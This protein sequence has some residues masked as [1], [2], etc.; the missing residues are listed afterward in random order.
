MLLNH[1]TESTL[2]EGASMLSSDPTGHRRE[3]LDLMNRLQDVGV[4]DMGDLNIPLIAVIGSQSSGK[5]S[6]IEAISGITLPRGAGTCTRCPTECRL[7]TS[8]DGQW[9][10]TVTLRFISE[11]DGRD[12][13]QPHHEQFGDKIFDRSLVED[14]V[15]RAQNAILNPHTNS[16]EFLVGAPDQGHGPELTFSRNIVSLSITGPDLTDLSFV[17]LP[18]LIQN[19]GTR[20]KES[21]IHLITKLVEW[22]ICKP[23]CIIL[24]TMNCEVDFATQGAHDLA[25]KHDREGIRTIGVLTK[26]DRIAPRSEELWTRYIRNEEEPLTH[27]WYCVK[28]PNAFDI[29]RGITWTQAQCEEE[30]FFKKV[31]PWDSV[32]STY[33]SFL[34]SRNLIRKMNLVLSDLA[35]KRTPQLIE[36][37]DQLIRDTTEELLKLPKAPSNDAI[38]EIHDMITRFAREVEGHVEG[39]EENADLF[40]GFRTRKLHFMKA[41]RCTAPGF[42]PWMKPKPRLHDSAQPDPREPPKTLPTPDFL[43]SEEV[44]FS[45]E[46]LSNEE[47]PPESGL[48]AKAIFMEDIQ[49]RIERSIGRGLPDSN[50]KL[51]VDFYIDSAIREWQFP[52]ILLVE[53]T[54]TMIKG[55]MRKI[56]EEHF[57]NLRNRD[58]CDSVRRAVDDH[59]ERCKDSAR[60]RV[61]CLLDLEK[62]PHTDNRHYFSQYKEKFFGYYRQLW[63]QYSG[64]QV[65]KELNMQPYNPRSKSTA[66]PEAKAGVEQTLKGLTRLGLTGIEPADLTRIIPE[67]PQDRSLEVMARVQ[68]YFQ[69]ASRRF[70][71][72]VPMT[73]DQELLRGLSKGLA[74]AVKKEITFN[75]A[76]IKDYCE[77]LLREPSNI[78]IARK[79]L[80]EKLDRLRRAKTE[81]AR[82]SGERMNSM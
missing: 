39:N 12:L 34:T 24:L 8:S 25:R 2:V 63:S 16:Q 32:E 49:S 65:L 33:R 47:E 54:H 1:E 74:S 79:K 71:D 44:D 30:K 10:C 81:L 43:A 21:D 58:L 70:V 52:T 38:S 15:R 62:A 9:S 51:V 35:M 13:G 37:V 77:E 6:L 48:G 55:H 56:V 59:L 68:A 45:S 28:R 60:F 67:G 76:D 61:Q 19:V 69:V 46:S 66:S 18:G 23:T 80:Q 53:N 64:K 14:R 42:H 41:I 7:R 75:R 36:E 72:Y 57:G 50:P 31:E 29:E 22:Y 4:Q 78:G 3:L 27:N 40:R 82:F 73:V 20:G 17:D 11:S 26:P 5:S